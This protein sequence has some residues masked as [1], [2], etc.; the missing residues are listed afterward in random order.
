MVIPSP[1]RVAKARACLNYLFT[2]TST[3][4]I[5]VLGERYASIKPR[6]GLT[7]GLVSLHDTSQQDVLATPQ[8]AFLRVVVYRILHLR[9]VGYH[10]VRHQT[11]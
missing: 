2:S 11:A 8:N 4:T 9:G 10:L 5:L 6:K 1:L 7:K 3:S